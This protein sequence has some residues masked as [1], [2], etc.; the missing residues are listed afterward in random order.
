M[1]EN[2]EDWVMC[3]ITRRF[4]FF[5]DSSSFFHGLSVLSRLV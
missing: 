3:T 2:R 4:V 1:L 5:V